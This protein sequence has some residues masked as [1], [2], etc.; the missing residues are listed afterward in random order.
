[1]VKAKN[2]R[3]KGKLRLSEYFKDVPLG[4]RVSLVLEKSE[5]SSVPFRMQG[6]SGRVV[7]SRGSHKI[8]QVND[9]AKEKL[10]VV[11]PVHLKVLQ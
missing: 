5:S 6:R 3:L 11:H 8:V 1:M 10:F 7:G 4:S 2:V 9:G